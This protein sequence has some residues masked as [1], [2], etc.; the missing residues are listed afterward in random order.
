MNM[1]GAPI[2]SRGVTRTRYSTVGIR[3]IRRQKKNTIL[4]ATC[5]NN[6][7]VCVVDG[8]YEIPSG[9]VFAT[10]KERRNSRARRIDNRV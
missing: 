3:W 9:I 7:A 4:L 5:S 2:K 8:Q 10:K 6:A 1:Q